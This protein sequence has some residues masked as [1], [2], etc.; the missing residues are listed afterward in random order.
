VLVVR[1]LPDLGQSGSV[2]FLPTTI[3]VPRGVT[4]LTLVAGN[5]LDHVVN[6]V[7]A[8]HAKNLGGV[9]VRAR[10]VFIHSL[11]GEPRR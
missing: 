3:R 10:P 8:K 5:V 6:L 9:E 11:P 4:L 1:D 7:P 2:T